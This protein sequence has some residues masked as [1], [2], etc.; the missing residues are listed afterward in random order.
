MSKSKSRWKRMAMSWMTPVLEK[1][2]FVVL[3]D[4]FKRERDGWYQFIGIQTARHEMDYTI[5]ISMNPIEFP[6]DSTGDA[7][8][9]N[10]IISVDCIIRTRIS[11]LEG[12]IRDVWKAINEDEQVGKELLETQVSLAVDEME[13][14]CRLLDDR[15]SLYRKYTPEVLIAMW[16]GIAEALKASRPLTLDKFG[17]KWGISPLSMAKLLSGLAYFHGEDEVASKYRACVIVMSEGQDYFP[18]VVRKLEFFERRLSG[19]GVPKKS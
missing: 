12:E 1:Q 3:A 11:K 7:M 15:E 2:G 16:R 4:E 9:S 19:R 17:R 5:N 18:S 14:F 13:G 10:D 6:S 8:A